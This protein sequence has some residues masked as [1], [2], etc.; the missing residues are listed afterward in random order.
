MRGI[1]LGINGFGAAARTENSTL[2]GRIERPRTCANRPG[3]DRPEGVDMTE[4][5][6]CRNCG[7]TGISRMFDYGC[8]FCSGTGARSNP[9]FR[10][11]CECGAKQ[12]R[13]TT[14][15]TANQ[16]MYKHLVTAHRYDGSDA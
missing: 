8:A 12:S 5:T 15:W 16:W 9:K 6:P 3:S 1:G 14:A 11:A 10:A 13:L 4:N 2:R 7:G